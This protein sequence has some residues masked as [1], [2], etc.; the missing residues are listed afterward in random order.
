MSQS[1][2]DKL[3]IPIGTAR[4]RLIKEILWKYVKLSGDDFCYRCGHQILDT[5]ELSVEHKIPWGI[6]DNP[7]NLY[8]DLDN[9]SFSHS[10]CNSTHGSEIKRIHKT[11]LDRRKYQRSNEKIRRN[12]LPK[13]VRQEKRRQQYLRTGK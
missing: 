11:D 12:N 5:S 10:K 4:A 8:F 7:V 6:S 1:K 3:G 9:I 2:S 13:E